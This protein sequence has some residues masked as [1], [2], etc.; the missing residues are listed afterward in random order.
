MGSLG[1]AGRAAGQLL[2]RLDKT[3]GH[4]VKGAGPPGRAWSPA[5]RP[6]RTPANEAE[7]Q[8]H[9]PA[10]VEGGTR[11]RERAPREG[12]VTAPRPRRPTR[13]PKGD[14]ETAQG[15]GGGD[16]GSKRPGETGGP[17]CPDPAPLHFLVEHVCP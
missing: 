6:L 8:A 11:A 9:G 14:P 4:T 12:A 15:P 17:Q 3:Q 7:T 13:A 1:Q 16:G 5:R 10:T 2:S